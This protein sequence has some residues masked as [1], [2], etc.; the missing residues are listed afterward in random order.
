M[1]LIRVR[2]DLHPAN[3]ALLASLGWDYEVTPDAPPCIRFAGRDNHLVEC[4]KCRR[5]EREKS[6]W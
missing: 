1:N 2:H 4:P 5:I 6:R 3:K